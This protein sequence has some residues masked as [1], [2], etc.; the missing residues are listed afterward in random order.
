MCDY[1]VI[2]WRIHLVQGGECQDGEG[3]RKQKYHTGESPADQTHSKKNRRNGSEQQG[4]SLYI[5]PPLLFLSQTMTEINT[6]RESTC[7]LWIRPLHEN[8]VRL[9]RTFHIYR[10]RKKRVRGPYNSMAIW[11]CLVALHIKY[12]HFAKCFRHALFLL[13]SHT[14]QALHTFF[15]F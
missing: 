4:T 2:G 9:R 11:K 7:F 12:Q 15:F 3:G 6:E 8:L 1:L 5:T 13:K 14:L 10:D